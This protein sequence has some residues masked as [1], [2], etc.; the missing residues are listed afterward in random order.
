[1][2]HVSHQLPSISALLSQCPRLAVGTIFEV[3][4]SLPL[5]HMS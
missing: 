4:D 3:S 5:C 1:M 2:T